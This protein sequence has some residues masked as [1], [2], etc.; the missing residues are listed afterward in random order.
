MGFLVKSRKKKSLL[1]KTF[2]EGGE[3]EMESPGTAELSLMRTS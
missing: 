2:P 3:T 1:S